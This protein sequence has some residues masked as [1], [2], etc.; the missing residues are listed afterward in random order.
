MITHRLARFA[1]PAALVFSLAACQDPAKDKVKATVSTAAPG[2]TTQAA[3]TGPLET[4]ALDAAQSS[5]GFTG[6]KV[7]GSHNG[8]FEKLEGSIALA[9]GKAEGGKIAVSVDVDSVKTDQEK[10][11]G[12]LK[13]ADFFDAAKF[14]KATFTS[15][16][17]KAGG[18]KGAT[19]TVTGELDLHGVKKTISFP[20]TIT[21]TPEGAV[22]GAEFTIN[23]KDF[24]IVYPGKPDDLIR[25]DVVL[26]LNL[27]ATRKKG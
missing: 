10:L 26:K 1:V 4:L 3:P 13:S 24:N 20:A 7:T 5:V 19:H 23:R 21:V 11:D 17:I 9:G 15:T 27:H 14:P 8:K 18:D 6:S 16:Q 12:H 25:D 22:G 2:A